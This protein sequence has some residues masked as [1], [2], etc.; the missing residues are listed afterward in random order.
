MDS[1]QSLWQTDTT[2]LRI[3]F[4][5]FHKTCQDQQFT[6]LEELPEFYKQNTSNDLLVES[7]V[8]L[9]LLVSDSACPRLHSAPQR[10][11]PM[12]YS[13]EM[14]VESTDPAQGRARICL[15]VQR[16]RKSKLVCK[17]RSLNV[18]CS[19]PSKTGT[20]VKDSE[21]GHPGNSM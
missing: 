6:I 3:N 5:Y 18:S 20:F 8:G 12:V 1:E 4:C 17:I 15:H 14:Q 13:L 21:P 19:V 7:L 2:R 9:A 10:S 11:A 16:P